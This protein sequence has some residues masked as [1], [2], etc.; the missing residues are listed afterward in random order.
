MYQILTLARAF[1]RALQRHINLEWLQLGDMKPFSSAE[2]VHGAGLALPRVFLNTLRTFMQHTF[3]LE[4]SQVY[5]TP[6]ALRSRAKV[7]R[8]GTQTVAKTFL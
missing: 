2:G 7:L 3:F 8:K 5:S 6:S 1:F 4:T